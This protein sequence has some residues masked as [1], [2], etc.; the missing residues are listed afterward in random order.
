MFD[1]CVV[2][3][4]KFKEGVERRWGR[5]FRFERFVFEREFVKFGFECGFCGGFCFYDGFEVFDF[6]FECGG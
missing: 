3:G 6:F 4:L 1:F 2:V 5:V